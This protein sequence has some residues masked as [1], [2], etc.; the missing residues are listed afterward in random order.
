MKKILIISITILSL[1][2]PSLSL[3]IQIYGHRGARGLSPENTIP[4]YKTALGVGVDFV[5]MDVNMSKDGVLVVTHNTSLDPDITR[6]SKGLWI[7]DKPLIKSLTVKQLK[8]YDV[9]KINPKSKYAHYF[10]DQYGLN[11]VRIP[12]LREVIKYAKKNGPKGLHFQIEVKT[13]PANPDDTNSP[14]QLAKALADIMEQENIVGL[15]EVQA[16]DFRVLL[17]LQKIN[18]KIKTAYLTDADL[19]K[20]M[21]NE[22]PK[23]AGLWSAG[24]LL[25]DYQNSIPKMIK[26][27][28]GSVWG[29]QDIEVTKENLAE[30]H[31]LGLKV[32]PWTW[33][34]QTGSEL[35]VPMM[36]KLIDLGVDGI[37]TDRP[38]ILRGLL[39]A[40]G[41]M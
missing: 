27:L 34:E 41:F 3:A 32:V 37:I 28:G 36:E 6:N 13:D 5:D 19:S 30:A 16:F 11:N 20:S 12:T 18:P 9:G 25:K 17:A 35:S 31:R 14:Q 22:N 2:I 29:P 24:Y 39:A 7:K 26:A 33:P 23:I 4:A 15:T 40:R 21:L 38:D 1:V 8:Q 10:P